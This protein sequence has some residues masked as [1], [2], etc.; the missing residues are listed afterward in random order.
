MIAVLQ[1]SCEIHVVVTVLGIT[2][3]TSICHDFTFRWN[4]M[5]LVLILRFKARCH[6]A[7]SLIPKRDHNIRRIRVAKDTTKVVSLWY[8]CKAILCTEEAETKMKV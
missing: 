2:C 6:H 5:S 4:E 8:Y 7:S 3:T 1:S